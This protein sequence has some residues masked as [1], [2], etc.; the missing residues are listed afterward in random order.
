MR[1]YFAG[2]LYNAM[3]DNDKIT[4]ITGDLGY[5]MF[6]RIKADFPRRFINVGASEQ[7]MV[8]VAVGMTYEG[9][10]PVCYSITSF[11]LTRPYEWIR[12]Y[13]N[14]ELAPVKLVGGGRDR[15]YGHDGFT[16]FAD[17]AK[18]ILD[19]F[20]NI[21]QFWPETNEDVVESIGDFLNNNK[22]SFLSLR[23]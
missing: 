19:G 16:H 23:R 12:N 3:T 15:D 21:E 20:P 14:H 17:D 5:G 7:T 4:V 10:T 8:G 18:Q 6:D 2:E 22:P 13:V 9:I 11:L 1:G